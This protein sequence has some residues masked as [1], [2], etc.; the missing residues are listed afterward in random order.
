MVNQN[1]SNMKK[2]NG[3]NIMLF[4]F[5]MNAIFILSCSRAFKNRSEGS[6]L[7][8]DRDFSEMSVREGMFKAFLFYMA[9]DGVI[10]RD[11][12]YPSKGKEDLRKRFEGR[13]DTSFVLSWDPIYEKISDSGELGYTYGTHSTLDKATGTITRGTYLTIWKKQSD[14]S[15]KFVLDTG[16]QGLP[17]AEK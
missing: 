10:L 4:V 14:G 2:K 7:K 16:T 9:D 6:L 11:N 12:S 1:L 15:W 8:A 13:S 17:E 5:I 3:I